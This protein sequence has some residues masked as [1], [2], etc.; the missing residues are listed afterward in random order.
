MQLYTNIIEPIIVII[1][2]QCTELLDVNPRL[3]LLCILYNLD[4][5]K[6]VF[7]EN[8]VICDLSVI[9]MTYPSI[10]LCISEVGGH[11]VTQVSNE[12]NGYFLLS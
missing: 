9:S 7:G 5:P 11:N 1:I 12:K 10:T 8:K 3:G 6:R 2:D 4:I